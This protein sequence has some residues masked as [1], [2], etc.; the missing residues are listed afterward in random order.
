MASIV[1]NKKR[2][3]ICQSCLAIA[4]ATRVFLCRH[5]ICLSCMKDSTIDEA[6]NCPKCQ[7]PSAIDH[8]VVDKLPAQRQPDEPSSDNREPP[9]ETSSSSTT[10][11]G[12]ASNLTNFSTLSLQENGEEIG[13]SAAS[14]DFDEQSADRQTLPAAVPPWA[15]KK[16]DLQTSQKNNV[17]GDGKRL[18]PPP[19]YS[20]LFSLGY[21][22]PSAAP[23]SQPRVPSPY[24]AQ[25]GALPSNLIQPRA[26]IYYPNQP[27]VFNSYQV[28][29]QYYPNQPAVALPQQFGFAYPNNLDL[30]PDIIQASGYQGG[31]VPQPLY[32]TMQQ[33]QPAFQGAQLPAPCPRVN[34]ADVA[35]SYCKMSP[36]VGPR[37]I[38]GVCGNYDLC[39]KCEAQPRERVHDPTH[40]FLK[41]KF[42][43]TRPSPKQRLLKAGA[44][45][46]GQNQVLSEDKHII[47]DRSRK[48]EISYTCDNC[49]VSPIVGT[50]YKCGNCLDF[51]LCERCELMSEVIHKAKHVFLV[52]R[53]PVRIAPSSTQLMFDFYKDET[54][55]MAHTGVN[56]SN[57]KQLVVGAR[58]KCGICD[59]YNLCEKCEQ[60][61]KVI[62]KPTHIFVKLKFP[63]SVPSSKKR[64][65]REESTVMGHNQMLAVTAH[66]I[67]HQKK[68]YTISFACD[69]CGKNPIKGTRY[70]CGICP[71]YD[72]CQRCEKNSEKLHPANHV[73]LVLKLPVLVN[74][75]T[76]QLAYDFY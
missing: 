58:F 31:A 10:D 22:L 76:P 29:P 16:A 49:S 53:H 35:C 21:Q 41:L 2:E 55:Q 8:A 24:G 56:C 74:V 20:E 25:S 36:I 59:D 67:P 12:L 17:D 51:D 37:Y 9:V 54:N 27:T 38:C 39:E 46:M 65:L 42:P 48:T 32:T 72:L 70:K 60:K 66:I 52:L 4:Q 75:T 47:K 7:A 62:H 26:P 1:P 57:C 64:A 40:L 19:A 63:S 71:N 50:R 43:A 61:C 28:A 14:Q 6:Q 68:K 23:N 73:F 34:P 69:A 33:V 5:T 13:A 15:K 11:L 3:V 45:D 18:T 30:R 44:I